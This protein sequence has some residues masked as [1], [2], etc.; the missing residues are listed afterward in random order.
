MSRGRRLPRRSPERI[1][2]RPAPPRHPATLMG[3]YVFVQRFLLFAAALSCLVFLYKKFTLQL[4]YFTCSS[5]IIS[6]LS[7]ANVILILGAIR[8]AAPTRSAVRALSGDQ[9]SDTDL[10]L[11]LSL[12]LSFWLIKRFTNVLL[13]TEV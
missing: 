8:P 6:H 12:F 7:D 11:F 2:A 4:F 13:S 3:S 9:R 10:T 5:D 1:P